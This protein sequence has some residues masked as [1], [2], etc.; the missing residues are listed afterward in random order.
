MTMLGGVPIMVVMPPRMVAKDSGIRVSAG[1]RFARRAACMSTGM[2][3]ARAATL[4]MKAES[5]APTAPMIAMWAGS[6]R[7]APAIWRVSI[8]MAPDR[9]SPRETTSTRAMTMTAGWP[10]PSKACLSSTT[11]SSTARVSAP[12]ATTS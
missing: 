7:P 11:P 2:S 1:E 9:A 12:K 4:F 5:A 6:E 10:K 3:S 8:S